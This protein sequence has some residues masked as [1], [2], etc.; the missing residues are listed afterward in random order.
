MYT[1]PDDKDIAHALA[2]RVNGGPLTVV[3]SGLREHVC[4]PTD[5]LDF[6]LTYEVAWCVDMEDE[7]CSIQIEAAD[8]GLADELPPNERN[9]PGPRM[10]GGK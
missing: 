3:V 4:D 2:G 5:P 9:E 8:K 6:G 7:G 1:R 10:D